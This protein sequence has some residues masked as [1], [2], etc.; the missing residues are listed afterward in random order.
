[1]DARVPHDVPEPPLADLRDVM[2]DGRASRLIQER[3][4]G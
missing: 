4:L 2:A 3:M 1:M